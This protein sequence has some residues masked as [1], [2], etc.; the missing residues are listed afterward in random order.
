MKLPHLLLMNS[1]SVFSQISLKYWK[2][3]NEHMFKENT[4]SME[5]A[6]TLSWRTSGA[7]VFLSDLW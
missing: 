3:V 2:K 4:S 7:I 5:V 1:V 6:S